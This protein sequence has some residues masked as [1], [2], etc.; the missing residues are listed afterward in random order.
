MSA[1]HFQTVIGPEQVIRPPDGTILP[2]GPI[3]VTIN[4][5]PGDAEGPG[6]RPQATRDWLLGL[7]E[8]AERAAPPLPTDLAEHHD[9]YAHGKPLS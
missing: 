8:E 6:T 7:A 4:T 2:E 9:Y 1:I 3:D 5:L